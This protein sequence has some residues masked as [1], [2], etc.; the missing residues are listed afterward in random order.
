MSTADA[1]LTAISADQHMVTAPVLAS[2]LEVDTPPASATRAANVGLQLADD[3]LMRTPADD[4]E[5]VADLHLRILGEGE[6]EPDP[7]DQNNPNDGAG[8]TH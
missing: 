1:D 7:A 2:D 6:T 3:S 4:P 5:R 8:T